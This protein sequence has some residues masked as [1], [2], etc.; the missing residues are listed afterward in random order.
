M[1]IGALYRRFKN[2]KF[3]TLVI[4]TNINELLVNVDL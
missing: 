2:L 3:S 4:V 1:N